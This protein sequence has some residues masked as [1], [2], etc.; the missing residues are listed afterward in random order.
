L[1]DRLYAT[2]VGGAFD[3]PLGER[4]QLT[5]VIG[6]QDFSGD[7]LRLHYRGNLIYSIAP[8]QGLS[9]QLRVRYFHDSDPNESDYF[10]P[11]WHAQVMPTLQLRRYVDGWRYAVAA[12]YG[13]QR[14]AG[15]SWR[16]ARLLEASVTSPKQ[17]HAWNFQAAF[18]YTNT[19]VSNGFTYDYRQVMLS[20]GRSF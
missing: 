3:L 14:E 18:T 13:R 11:G 5:T 15:M 16:P 20:L 9:A 12:G 2:Y 17:G 6:A 19:P 8:R 1:Q 7:N 4:A 10:A